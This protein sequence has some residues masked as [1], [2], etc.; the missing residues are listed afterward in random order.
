[1]YFATEIQ[2]LLLI[3][4][5][6]HQPSLQIIQKKAYSG[7]TKNKVYSVENAITSFYSILTT[8]ESLSL[9]LSLSDISI[10]YINPS[11]IQLR[12]QENLE[13]NSIERWAY[14]SDN[15]DYEE[16]FESLMDDLSKSTVNTSTIPQ[17]YTDSGYSFSGTKSQSRVCVNQRIAVSFSIQNPLNEPLSIQ[18]MQLQVSDKEANV[19]VSTDSMDLQPF[20]TKT[21]TL[22]VTPKKPTTF[23]IK[24]VTFM[25]SPS[26]TITQ[27]LSLPKFR[28][29]S[30]PSQRRRIEYGIS[31]RMTVNVIPAHGV[32]ACKV[33]LMNDD[34][35][36]DGRIQRHPFP[37]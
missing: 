11:S 3:Q 35:F 36:V 9:P 22:F 32:V 14:L 6:V 26:I 16:A 25:I 28:L 15:R 31:Q 34:L 1:M 30:T 18:S 13:E 24:G 7:N 27:A 33:C 5:P 37:I 2:A 17:F 29:N 10:P 4:P 21:V 8:M 20:E 12:Y 23:I 19:E